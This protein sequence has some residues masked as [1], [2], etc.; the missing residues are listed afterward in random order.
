MFFIKH[1]SEALQCFKEYKARTETAHPGHPVQRLRCDGA[2]ENTSNAFRQF[3]TDNGIK[4]ELTTAS[5]PE[6]DGVSE[7]LNRTLM[8]KARSMLA[9]AGLIDSD[10]GKRFWAYAVDTANVLRNV[11][12]TTVSP[13]ATITPYEAYTGRKPRAVN[14]RAF[15]ADIYVHVQDRDRDK[16]DPRGVKMIFVGYADEYKAWPM[17]QRRRQ[18]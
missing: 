10:E 5:T 16:V 4:Y 12:P 17:L 13:D 11:S 6:Q 15:G 3:L 8:D 7:R 9:A 14:L 1:K 2:G 18:Q